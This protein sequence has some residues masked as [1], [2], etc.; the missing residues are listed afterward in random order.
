MKLN[1]NI[2]DIENLFSQKCIWILN[3][4]TL[5]SGL[6]TESER[7]RLSVSVF[8]TGSQSMFKQIVP[9]IIHWTNIYKE[10][11]QYTCTNPPKV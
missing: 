6:L 4:L 7:E 11:L 5:R 9:Y 1:G 10:H 8:M 2:F 3:D